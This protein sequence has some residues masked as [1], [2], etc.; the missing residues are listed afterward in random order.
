MEYYAVTTHKDSSVK[1]EP[2]DW[3][4]EVVNPRYIIDL[5]LS[6]FNLS[7]QTVDIVNDLLKV[8]FE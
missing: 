1:N 4:D 5:L 8:T 3:S 2:N 6:V 7:V